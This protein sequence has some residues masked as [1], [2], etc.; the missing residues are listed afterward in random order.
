MSKLDHKTTLR[1]SFELFKSARIKAIQE[2][3]T[4]SEV[5]RRF[6]RAWVEGIIELPE[7]EKPEEE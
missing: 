5:I 2:N 1:I 4:L 3:T 7:Q 6:V